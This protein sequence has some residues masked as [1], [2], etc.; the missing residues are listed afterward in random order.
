MDEVNCALNYINY[1]VNPNANIVL[2]EAV[3]SKDDKN[4]I[5]TAV[6]TI[7]NWNIL[8]NQGVSIAMT[9]NVDIQKIKQVNSALKS[10][11]D[12]IKNST[13]LLKAKFAQFHITF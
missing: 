12:I 10:K 8:C 11:T 4:I 13:N 3:L 2:P 6:S 5:D 1:F 9:N 7:D